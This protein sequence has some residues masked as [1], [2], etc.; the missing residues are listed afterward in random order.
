MGH[1]S[2]LDPLHALADVIRPDATRRVTLHENAFGRVEDAYVSPR[3]AP[4]SGH[5]SSYQIV[6]PYHGLF[7]PVTLWSTGQCAPKVW[8]I[9]SKASFHMQL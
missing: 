5:E 6:V 7:A 4:P 1:L 9:L 3:A 2:R 8:Q